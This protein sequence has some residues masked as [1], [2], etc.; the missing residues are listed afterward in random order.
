MSKIAERLLESQN[1]ETVGLKIPCH[2]SYAICYLLG[3]LLYNF[4]K[5]F[6]RHN[7]VKYKIITGAHR[8]FTKLIM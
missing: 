2:E 6:K 3:T 4:H 7:T 8:H 5:H 1:F